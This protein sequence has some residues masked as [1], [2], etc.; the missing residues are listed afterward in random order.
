MSRKECIIIVSDKDLSTDYSRRK[1][2]LGT[3]A[4][5]EDGRPCFY[6]KF[7]KKK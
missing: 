6:V 2:P 7:G 1:Y 3:R 5:T 4:K